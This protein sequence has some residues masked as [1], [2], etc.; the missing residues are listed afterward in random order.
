M[1]RAVPLLLLTP[2]FAQDRTPDDILKLPVPNATRIAYG[3]DTL[4]FGELRVPAGKGPH[5]VVVVIHGGC[6]VAKLGKLDD[7]AV[8]LDLVR[9]IAA[10]LTAN[11]F[12]TWNL[13]YR[14]L[15]NDG[16]GW[17]GSFR[18]IAA[19]ADHLRQIA[20]KN[21]LDL[22]ASSRSAT[23]PADT[24]RCGLPRVPNCPKRANST[25]RIPCISK[26]SSISMAPA[27]SRRRF[28]SSSPSAVRL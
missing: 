28:L 26:A 13:E 21:N 20:S 9:P 7:R 14:R 3:T 8:A 12:A 27:T 16:G 4:Q 23:L 24:S 6:W 25:S 19:G 10:D 18:D 11:G 15:G 5:P 22:T 17:P 2:L 1:Y